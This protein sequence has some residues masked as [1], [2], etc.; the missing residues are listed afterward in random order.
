M[1]Q[2]YLF[3]LMIVGAI[4]LF[5]VNPVAAQ[6]SGNTI[7][8]DC[9][10]EVCDQ[11]T[12]FAFGSMANART[13]NYLTSATI[14]QT[15]IGDAGWALDSNNNPNYATEL[16]FWSQ[17]KK[18]PLAPFVFA[19]DGDFSNKI[20]ISW[21]ED[22]LS[23]AVDET[24]K[25]YREGDLLATLSSSTY[26]YQDFNILAGQYY[27]YEVIGGNQYGDGETGCDIGF[28]N[29]NGTVTGRVETGNDTPVPDVD[30]SLTPLSGAALEFDGVDDYVEVADAS[31]LQITDAITVECWVNITQKA[32]IGNTNSDQALVSKGGRYLL[33]VFGPDRTIPGRVEFGGC[34]SSSLSDPWTNGS[35]D[36]A[37]GT[38][39]HVAATYD[40]S[41]KRIY[42]DGVLDAEEATTGILAASSS[43][44]S[45]GASS[46]ARFVNGL[47]DEVRIWNVAR[48]ADEIQ[49]YMGRSLSGDDDGLVLNLPFNE[50]LGDFA[51][52]LTEN[53]FDGT[54]DGPTWSDDP[55]PV[56]Y[57]GTTDSNGNYEINGINYGSG[58]TFTA[59]PSK[60]TPINSYSLAF[61][62]VDDYVEVA[63]DDRLEPG[64]FTIELW[65]K[66]NATGVLMTILDKRLNDGGYLQGYTFQATSSGQVRAGL[67]SGDSWNL[68]TGSTWTVGDWH[69]V[70][71]VYDATS[72]ELT[73]YEDGILMNQADVT[74]PVFISSRN[75]NI[76]AT[77][78]DGPIAEPFSGHVDDIRIWSVARSQSQI[79]AAMNN[80]LT[81]EEDGLAAYWMCNEGS[82]DV[83]MDTSNDNNP[84]TDPING[85]LYNTD[86]AS[87][88]SEDSPNPETVVHEFVPQTRVV[89]LSPSN[90]AV[91]NVDFEDQTLI[92][93]TGFVRFEGTLCFEEDVEIL[94]DGVSYDPPIYSDENGTFTAEF[95]PGSTHWLT[96]SYE[97]HTFSPQT[98]E[99]TDLVS[100][101]AGIV[102]KDQTL[103]TLTVHVYGGTE[104]CDISLV[105]SSGNLQVTVGTSPSCYEV[106]QNITSGTTTVFENLPAYNFVVTVDHPDGAIEFDGEQVDLRLE[107]GLLDFEYRADIVVEVSGFAPP[108][109]CPTNFTGPDGETLPARQVLYQDA[110]HTLDFS[111]YE[112]Y[113]PY[114]DTCPIDTGYVEI[115]NNIA[116]TDTTL[117]FT[118]GEFTNY[119]FRV[120]PPNIL[121]GGDNPYQKSIQAAA[122]ELVENDNTGNWVAS[123]TGNS[124]EWVYVDGQ[125][126]RGDQF[127]TLST[128]NMPL[129]VVRDP[130]GD[131][132][133]AYIEQ[134][135]SYSKTK[136]FMFFDDDN[137][138][139]KAVSHLAPHIDFTVPFVGVHVETDLDIDLFDDWQVQIRRESLYDVTVETTINERFSTSDLQTNWVEGENMGDIF[140]G[141]GY[142]MVVTD[143]DYL[144]FVDSTCTLAFETV[145]TI[146]SLRV[147]STYLYSEHH[148]RHSLIP[149]LGNLSVDSLNVDLD[150]LTEMVMELAYWEEMLAM[151][152]SLK[153]ATGL[154]ET[155]QSLSFDGGAGSYDYIETTVNQTLFKQITYAT[156]TSEI[157]WNIGS[158]L[159]GIGSGHVFAF[160]TVSG[161]FITN[162][163]NESET[164]ADLYDLQ[165][166]DENMAALR[167]YYY[168]AED[169]FYLLT[170]TLNNIVMTGYNLYT[171]YSIVRTIMG[172]AVTPSDIKTGL[173]M[174]I[175]TSSGYAAGAVNNALDLAL[176]TVDDSYS[177][178]WNR[179]DVYGYHLE[180]D[181]PG[182]NIWVR[183]YDDETFGLF[184]ETVAG[185]TK[186]PWEEN[187]A[188]REDV[189][190]AVTPSVQT[191]IN[192]DELAVFTLNAGNM[193]ETDEAGWYLIK[194]LQESNPDGATIRLN[195]DYD[196]DGFL[197]NIPPLEVIEM[198]T[199]VERGPNAYDYDDLKIVLYSHCEYD[200]ALDG[201]N[202]YQPFIAD[203][204]SFSV[205][206]KQPC[207]EVEITNPGDGWLLDAA[208][209]DTLWITVQG[210]ELNT[211]FSEIKLQ[212]RPANTISNRDDVG[213]VDDQPTVIKSLEDSFVRTP[214]V[215][216]NKFNLSIP[217]IETRS[218]SISDT[219]VPTWQSITPEL[220]AKTGW[221]ID[222]PVKG[223]SDGGSI[224]S[225]TWINFKTITYADLQMQFDVY[226][227]EY[228]IVPWNVEFLDDG[229]YEIRAKTTCVAVDDIAGTSDVLYGI[230]ER[231]AP[232]VFGTPQP[233]DGV[234]QNGDDIAISFT[235]LIIC[236]NIV[237]ADMF[238]LN[239]LGLYDTTT[240]QLLDIDYTCYENTIILEPSASNYY[241]ENHTLRAE[242]TGIK[243]LYENAMSD[244]VSWEFWVNRN[245]MAWSGGDVTASKY[246][247][248]TITVTRQLVN[249]G[250][251]P[252]AFDFFDLDPNPGRAVIQPPDWLNVS[253]TTGTVNPGSAQTVVIEFDDQLIGGIYSDSL[254]VRT[255]MG[256][257]FIVIN[258]DNYCYA[259]DWIVDPSQFIHSMTITANVDFGGQ[260]VSN[261]E[262]ML[263]GAFIN[264]EPHGV[265]NLEYI[266]TADDYYAF[267]TVYGDNTNTENND[268][269]TFRVW[270]SL[271]CRE[272]GQ[273]LD[274]I[275]FEADG[276]VGN[277]LDPFTIRLASLQVQE[278][279]LSSGW[280][281]FSLNVSPES[282]LINEVLS[283]LAATSQDLIKDQ[284]SYAQY[285][286]G[287]GWVGQLQTLN[288]T[289][290]YMVRLADPQTFELSG[291]RIEPA[292][293]PISVSTG[294]NWISYPLSA[295]QEVGLALGSLQPAT[296]DLIKSQ[297]CFAQYAETMGWLGS[298][299]YLEPG[300]GYRL[301]VAASDTLT[302]P[303]PL[304][305]AASNHTAPGSQANKNLAAP[306]KA[307]LPEHWTS[308]PASYEFNMTLIGALI[309][310][311]ERADVIGA[312]VGDECRGVAPAV[313]IEALAE[314]RYFLMIYGN[315]PGETVTFQALIGDEQTE[316]LLNEPVS[317]EPNAVLGDA[318][319]PFVWTCEA[320]GAED[321]P[322][323]I[324][325]EFS[326]GQNF[327][328]PFNP[329]TVIS[330][331][332]PAASNL[333]MTIYN[334][335]GQRV[336][337]L[338]TGKWEPGYHSVV[339]NA[340]NDNGERVRSGVYFYRMT[341][342][343]G[344]D[345]TRK[346][347]L[348]KW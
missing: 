240:D 65:A 31:A 253:P 213:D 151:N 244:T 252:M 208:A 183:V 323:S 152:D 160:K 117:Y 86:E 144:T 305:L 112:D 302:Y 268:P 138:R 82:G 241:Y 288:S 55:A 45:I 207:S 104:T 58:T 70:A 43:A 334:I 277:G 250:S 296:G 132:S 312:F 44:L 275:P 36:I 68:L 157:Q 156:Q 290:M 97:G 174:I 148:I 59:T 37:D 71:L 4:G 56:Y 67:G 313:H 166:Y 343:T 64:S 214:V 242:L 22:A 182:D 282:N 315:T 85:A 33:N 271:D 61:D 333:N 39:H 203:T 247:D 185:A 317:F 257:E 146:D 49:T 53:D 41:Y 336:K 218:L 28:V 266:P 26:Q 121:S 248:E 273:D 279:A 202:N 274:A 345:A 217:R 72:Y 249:N 199:T 335:V 12:V 52:D 78:K 309:S 136:H 221:T 297:F 60:E 307:T 102:F 27:D 181:D 20:V 147:E 50:G 176:E 251:S 95:E 324:P 159:N 191:D 66:L 286:D 115:Y 196:S 342:D 155:Q 16:G 300:L 347:L 110:Y 29:P 278:L 125:R 83:I 200:L 254:L 30:V 231:Y 280:S 18:E 284:L 263:V 140:V 308:D 90:T 120:G 113:S 91:N 303:E 106:V 7:Y 256:D 260:V 331:Q 194:T 265:A 96:P 329:S 190:L 47:V 122:Y 168:N 310:P 63:H 255:I 206:Y 326:L 332:L 131:N 238:D 319:S 163:F 209:N 145:P 1:R 340:D 304:T 141:L 192:P 57:V 205:H 175:G 299:Q 107:D 114:G 276:I 322:T 270:S 162:A 135:Q 19:A 74:N 187:T 80:I 133:Y 219:P 314:D 79:Q 210:Y 330:F 9:D 94:V 318:V 126:R 161:R 177:E 76:G 89:T 184:F 294:W 220:L 295:G 99:V 285:V 48:S 261:L 34:C 6:C 236:N 234:L 281:W 246:E 228:I 230:I 232:M 143:A 13:Q 311:Y 73:F 32:S 167:G 173:L 237:E 193:T 118:N 301:K 172:A 137:S 264:G 224:R 321:V 341:T 93:V 223:N 164:I 40:G 21:Y 84:S 189:S 127:I 289:S 298:L 105:P 186:C 169:S 87:I 139:W 128:G 235:E 269:I 51:F 233:S 88:W 42:I 227:V 272:M 339:W 338:A 283:D 101:V 170:E 129:F 46:G 158:T 245:P 103:R 204:V 77:L 24:W 171:V 116:E 62:G 81:G 8:N 38:W 10:T 23:P 17:L 108:T 75:L 165:G 325:A 35:T 2:K 134:G 287:Y 346:L 123:R 201:L 119:R 180:D 327:P 222:N 306:V 111:I 267:L 291:Y 142:N 3:W 225:D 178:V 293:N 15:L 328:N 316:I 198:T 25:V 150:L 98:W 216:S 212:F 226:G 197:V 100:P 124:I 215:D 14:G 348:L 211:M 109:D 292:T 344:F 262:A 239:M 92:P 188:K 69:H 258:L 195:G 11:T 54:V 5:N 130:P 259:P 243:D 179:T 153:A 154:F 229:A 320:T 149:A 337:T